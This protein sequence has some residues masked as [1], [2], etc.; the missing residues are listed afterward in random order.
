M[1]VA[2]T[3]VLG[4]W[5]G[6]GLAA[7]AI[8]FALA[9][10]LANASAATA[11]DPQSPAV[12]GVRFGGDSGQTRMVIESDHSLSSHLAIAQDD[13]RHITVS[14]SMVSP[15]NRGSG[16]PFAGAGFGFV[17][18]WRI[19]SG[20]HGSRLMLE[21]AKDCEVAHR[22]ALGPTGA[23]TSYRYV[24]D[25]APQSPVPAVVA[26]V[27]A[28]PTRRSH[29]EVRRSATASQA[30]ESRPVPSARRTRKVIVVD[31]G[32]GGH[33]PGAQAGGLNEKD[34]TLATAMALRKRLERSGRY[35][36]VMTRD[37][38]VFIPLPVRVQIARRAGADLFLSLHADSAGDDPDT[39]GASVYT[40]SDH[41]ETRVS[42]V[43]G[44]TEWFSRSGNH[45]GDQAVGRILLDLTQRSTLNRSALFAG[46]LI[47]RVSD[48]IDLLP[49]T[50]R[51]AGYFVLL[52]PD[53]PAA[54]LEMGFI[55][56]HRDQARLIDP[57]E[58]TKLTGA[59]ADAI[60]AYFDGQPDPP[61]ATRKTKT[62]VQ[63]HA[64]K[65]PRL[66]ATRSG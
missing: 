27:D 9:F 61:P 13:P 33:D 43:L 26:A 14:L 31:A 30:A 40:L 22:F 17:K 8:A 11:V 28:T 44:Q 24:I 16:L 15:P 52:A 12:L 63:E 1:R 41:G 59:I 64:I 54:L 38:D 55:S 46:L 32:H 62:M 6:R 66:P 39:H 21:L 56:S 53:V 19:E 36:V 35:K 48:K 23:A 60:D 2:P 42:E 3:S 49:R 10:P 45:E 51:D 57:A 47:D 37:S 18:A 29:G 34:I 58:R 4:K 20:A 65:A 50:H 5:W 7:T 25:I